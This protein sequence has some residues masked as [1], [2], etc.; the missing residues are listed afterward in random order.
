MPTILAAVFQAAAPQSAPPLYTDNATLWRHMSDALHQSLDRVLSLLIAILPGIVAFFIALGIFT[1][2]GIVFSAILRRGLSLAKFDDRMARYRGSADWTPLT[3]PTAMAGRAAFWGCVLIGLL[4]GI[5]AFDTSYASAAALP[6]SLLPYFTRIV[7]AA[8]LLI[9]GTIV[10]RFLARSV[11][12]GAVNANLQYARFL[13]LGVKWLVLVL[14]AAMALD[15]LEI[16]G[17][18]VELAFSILFGGIV[19][20]LALAVGLGSR[21]LVSRSLESHAER[22]ADQ[23]PEHAPPNAGESIR[24]F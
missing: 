19:L 2:I 14:T 6:I 20:A 9:V 16:G 1:L 8:F 10:A 7:G 24:H 21:E 12:I 13:S 22:T 4:I 23:N 15:H 17:A 18:I 5:S 3:S 11:L